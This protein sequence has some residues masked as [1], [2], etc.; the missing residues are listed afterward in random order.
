VGKPCA[1]RNCEVSN[2]SPRGLG[3][4]SRGASL[5]TY[6]RLSANAAETVYRVFRRRMSAQMCLRQ[7]DYS[8][9]TPTPR[10]AARQSS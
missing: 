4:V 7:R 1:K 5:I 6:Y 2:Q 10:T 9:I 8:H 3:V